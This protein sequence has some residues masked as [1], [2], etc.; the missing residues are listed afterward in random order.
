MG[1]MALNLTTLN[2]RGLRDPSKC[3]R[4]LGEFSNLSVDVAAVQKT[5]FTCAAICRVMENDYAVL[6]AYGSRSSV[7]VSFLIGRSLN[8]D[9]NLVLVDDETGWL[10]LMLLLKA[11]SSRWPWSMRPIS[12]LRG[13]PFLGI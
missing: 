10:W 8:A 6:S 5:L 7:G 2:V 12:L 11:S 13:F 4:L 3:A 1:S 9:V